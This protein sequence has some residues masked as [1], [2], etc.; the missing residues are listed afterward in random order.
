MPSRY[1]TLLNLHAIPYL[2][3]ISPAP[4]KLCR[5]QMDLTSYGASSICDRL[6]QAEFSRDGILDAIL[7]LIDRGGADSSNGTSTCSLVRGIAASSPKYTEPGLPATGG[8]A[9]PAARRPGQ[10]AHDV[11]I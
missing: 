10:A 3:R 9:V 11:C 2:R 6:M 8:L 7:T 1:P 4:T 5:A